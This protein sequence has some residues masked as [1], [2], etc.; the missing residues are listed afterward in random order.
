MN[1]LRRIMRTLV[2]ATF[3]FTLSCGT[4]PTKPEARIVEIP[5]GSA[6][7]EAVAKWLA[8]DEDQSLEDAMRSKTPE[9]RFFTAEMLRWRGD[10]ETAFDLYGAFLVDFPK[11]P[12]SRYAAARIHT[13]RNSV[14]DFSSRAPILFDRIDWSQLKPLTR[15]YL[16]MAQQSA[17]YQVWNDSSSPEPFDGGTVGYPDK[18]NV[19]PM[20]SPWRLLDFDQ[21]FAPDGDAVSGRAGLHQH[22]A[23]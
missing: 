8:G 13:L 23:V 21:A 20:A 7:S 10:I 3:L 11:H 6:A 12:F 14:V 5:Q 4:T 19:T 18:W 16:A 2:V 22:Q 15:V 17:E 9:A 1:P